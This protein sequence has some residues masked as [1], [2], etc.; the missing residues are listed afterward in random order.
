M[1]PSASRDQPGWPG[2]K[3]PWRLPFAPSL[4]GLAPGGVC[5]AAP[6]ARRAVGSYPTLSPLP[7]Q[8]IGPS[9]ADQ[10][11]KGADI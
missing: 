10:P 5:R 8:Y 2:R 11:P 6:V 1:L 4:F 9:V 3:R 7:R